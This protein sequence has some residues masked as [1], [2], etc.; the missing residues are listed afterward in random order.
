MQL[1]AYT[2]K[3]GLDPKQYSSIYDNNDTFY[4]GGRYDPTA[5]ELKMEKDIPVTKSESAAST[6]D[7]EQIKKII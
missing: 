4:L 5:L 3:F 6:S 1:N 2:K 7:S